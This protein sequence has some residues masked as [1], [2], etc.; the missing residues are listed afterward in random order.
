MQ[1]VGEFCG[2]TRPDVEDH[3]E[4]GDPADARHAMLRMGLEFGRQHDIGRQDDLAIG[5]ARCIH[6]RA[7]GRK[8]LFLNQ[9]FT[10]IQA[11]R[12]EER[13]R[14]GA[15]DDEEIDLLGEIAEQFELG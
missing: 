15:A 7:G 5:S 12:G 8:H 1:L 6:H 11:A 14:H 4:V 10:H 2:R 9:R 13:V 3:L